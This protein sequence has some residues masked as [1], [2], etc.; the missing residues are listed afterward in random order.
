MKKV[1]VLNDNDIS[2]SFHHHIERVGQIH[3]VP[4]QAIKSHD[5]LNKSEILVYVSE[6]Y[7][8]NILVKTKWSNEKTIKILNKTYPKIK[9]MEK[10]I[11]KLKKLSDKR[12]LAME[13][14]EDLP[15]TEKKKYS[16]K[17]MP[18]ELGICEIVDI[19]TLKN[20]L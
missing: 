13:W 1:T 15:R 17:R 19:Y 18:M 2:Q 12:T 9:I 7:G 8:K 4:S 11:Q 10:I 14:W 20:K 5:I 6:K 3:S 16:K